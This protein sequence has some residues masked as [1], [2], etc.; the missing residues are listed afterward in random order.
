VL[1]GQ[2]WRA[3]PLPLGHARSLHPARHRRRA[4]NPARTNS[5][6]C[7]VNPVSVTLCF[8]CISAHLRACVRACVRDIT[9]YPNLTSHRP[10]SSTEVSEC[11]LECHINGPPSTTPTIRCTSRCQHVAMPNMSSR[12][13]ALPPEHCAVVADAHGANDDICRCVS[14]WAV[15]GPCCRLVRRAADTAIQP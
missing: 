12:S 13:N 5:S 14:A 9:F 6:G 8:N 11:E 2:T 4:E 3:A 10:L 15:R 7:A 1:R